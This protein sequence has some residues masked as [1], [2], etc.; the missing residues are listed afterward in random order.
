MNNEKGRSC[1]KFHDIKVSLIR[2]WDKRKNKCERSNRRVRVVKVTVDIHIS[3][4]VLHL[5]F[6]VGER[7]RK[8]WLS[9]S[10]E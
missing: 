7:R 5:E 9:N 8:N 4:E 2:D 10:T 6:G 1:P 3:T